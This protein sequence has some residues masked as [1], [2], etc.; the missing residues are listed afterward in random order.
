MNEKKWIDKH[1]L[2]EQKVYKKAIDVGWKVFNKGWPD[3]L[4][5]D[6]ETKTAYCVEAKSI[7]DSLREHQ[8]ELHKVLEEI[9]LKV[10]VIYENKT[11]PVEIPSPTEFIETN[12][13]DAFEKMG[14]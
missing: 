6:P 9:G 10:V 8:I 2:F 11:H 5:F 7:N 14:T 3:F 1:C 4:L 12:Y 13:A